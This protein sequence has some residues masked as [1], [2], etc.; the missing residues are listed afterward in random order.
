MDGSERLS[1][2]PKA[3]QVTSG[4]SGILN[5]KS[6]LLS[7][8]QPRIS[9][10][11]CWKGSASKPVSEGPREC[12]GKG[13]EREARRSIERSHMWLEHAR[14]SGGGWERL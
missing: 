5:P 4:R 14:K 11:Q 2:L 3:V 13:K 12:L 8:V 1:N 9:V 10:S 6:I 7:T